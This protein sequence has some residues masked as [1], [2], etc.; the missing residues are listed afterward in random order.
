MP[1]TVSFD[2]NLLASHCV[3]DVRTPLEFVEDC[4]PAHST[5]RFSPTM[6]GSRSEHFTNRMVP[7]QPESAVCN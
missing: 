7:S 5:F 1:E 4:L 3:V 6:K 2:E